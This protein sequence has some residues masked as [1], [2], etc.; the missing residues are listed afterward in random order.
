MSEHTVY[1]V[2]Q[3]SRLLFP[4]TKKFYQS[5]YP[6]GR[7]NKADPIWL[8]KNREILCAYRLKQFGDDQLLTAM[9][10]KPSHRKQGLASYLLSHTQEAL[11]AKQTYC[12]AFAYLESFY[13]ENGF[14]TIKHQDLPRELEERFIRY[15]LSGKQLTPMHFQLK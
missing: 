13:Q 15:T 11:Q 4:L 9:V 10:T 1:T 8:L 5:Y 14:L 6:S 12:F 2:E 3:S 7:P